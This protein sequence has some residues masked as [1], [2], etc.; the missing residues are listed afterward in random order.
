[1]E[2]GIPVLGHIGVTKQRIVLS[3][4]ISLPAKDAR[5]SHDMIQDAMAMAKAGALRSSSNAAC[6]PG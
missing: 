1:V 3:G 6:Q 5:S 2:S 4:Q